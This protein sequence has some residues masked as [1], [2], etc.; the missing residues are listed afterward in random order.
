LSQVSR[1]LHL[2]DEGRV[3]N[4]DVVV[5]Q[6]FWTPGIEA[7]FYAAHIKN[8]T[9]DYYAQLWAQTVDIYDFTWPMRDWM[10][11]IEISYDGMM[12]G[13]FVGSSIHKEQLREAGFSAPIHVIGLPI[14]YAEV[15]GR[16]PDV[17]KQNQV[18][19][20]SRLDGEKQPVFMLEVAR[21]F[22]KVYPDWSWMVTTSRTQFASNAPG[23]I[24]QLKQ[25]ASEQPRFALRAGLTKDEYYQELAKSKIIFN[26]SLQD[27][28]SWTLLEGCIAGCDV[29]YPNWRSFPECVPSDRLYSAFSLESALSLFHQVIDS[30]RTHFEIARLCDRGRYYY[31]L[32]AR[33]SGRSPQE[34][35]IW[36]G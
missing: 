10:R 3:N 4:G 35:N 26:C 8:I 11:P 7:I 5:L 15:A 28:V 17:K 18:I 16:L 21:Q 19:F 23:M 24:D 30:P 33:Q 13:I 32:F 12:T 6:D 1:F 20:A 2:V 22:L 34:V 9:L 27:Y 14:D 36:N 29:V 25:L 31:P